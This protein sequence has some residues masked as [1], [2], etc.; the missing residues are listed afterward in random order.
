ME[1]VGWGGEALSVFECGELVVFSDC[2][3]DD[4][5]APLLD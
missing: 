4:G 5:V 3:S 2:L 1:C